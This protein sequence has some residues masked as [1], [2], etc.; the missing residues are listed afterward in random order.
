MRPTTSIADDQVDLEEVAGVEPVGRGET[1]V[2]LEAQEE[3]S[4]RGNTPVLEEVGNRTAFVDSADAR[5][6]QGG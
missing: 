5:Q 6:Q 1:W 3:V 4:L 2:P